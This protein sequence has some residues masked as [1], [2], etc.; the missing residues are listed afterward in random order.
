MLVATKRAKEAKHPAPLVKGF[1][2][3]LFLECGLSGETV[4]AY[5]RDLQEFWDHLVSRDVEPGEISVEDIQTHMMRL[6]S[7]GLAVSLD[8]QRSGLPAI[9]T[10]S[11]QQQCA[12]VPTRRQ[13]IPARRLRHRID[14]VNRSAGRQ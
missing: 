5:K 13:S 7:R 12:V 3:Y 9:G 11:P 14:L 2:D 1:L 8:Q 6:S 4:T 10:V